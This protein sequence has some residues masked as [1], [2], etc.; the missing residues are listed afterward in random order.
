LLCNIYSY[1]FFSS[2]AFFIKSLAL[3][4][5]NLYLSISGSVIQENS[6][7]S[8]LNLMPASP[9]SIKFAIEQTGMARC[10]VMLALN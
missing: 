10:G 1:I 5:A 7:C 8:L 4:Q 2:K 9:I 6:V 3:G